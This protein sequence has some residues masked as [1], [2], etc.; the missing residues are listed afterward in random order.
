MKTDSGRLFA[1]RPLCCLLL[2]GFIA[3][4]DAQI[5]KV[6]QSFEGATA[7]GWTLSGSALLTAAGATPIDP[8]GSGWLRMTPAINFELGLALN[9]ALTFSGGQ[10]VVV[11]FN[12][13]SWGGTGGVGADGMTVFLFDSSQANPMT[14][15]MYGGGLGYCGGAGGYLAIGLDEYGNF[16]NP[17]DRCGAASGGPGF[18]PESLVIR[19]PLSA[20]NQF[21]T[22]V[23]VPGGIDDLAATSRPSPRSVLLSLTPAVAGGYTVTAQ[24]RSAA[25]QP[26]VTLFSNQP[27]PYVAPANLS[28]GFSGGTGGYNNTHELQ[29]L[30]AA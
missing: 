20:N 6:Q 5:V 11:E 17:N 13:V 10:A 14:G 23:A 15:A 9:S 4:A 25:G 28:I 12:Y 30:A 7:P 26:F 27:F 16:S 19:G 22:N 24:F 2:A 1:M 21:V 18:A 8:P 29:G 3:P